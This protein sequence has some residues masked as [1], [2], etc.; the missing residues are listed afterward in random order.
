MGKKGPGLDGR[1]PVQRGMADPAAALARPA[2]HL[3]RAHGDL[4]A[5]GITVD[6]I[7][8]IFAVMALC[9]QHLFFV[10]TKRPERMRD[11]LS[12]ALSAKAPTIP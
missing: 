3:R 6:M 2:R 1:G 4:F 12:A 7:D 10:L 11:Y 9:P 5:E 8:R